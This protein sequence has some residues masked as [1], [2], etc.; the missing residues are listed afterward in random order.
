MI[1]NTEKKTVPAWA[2]ALP[3]TM[4]TE[5]YGGTTED[6]AR[7][8]GLYDLLIAHPDKW[9]ELNERFAEGFEGDTDPAY[10]ATW[11][12]A[13]GEAH[14]T[15]RIE[16]LRADAWNAIHEIRQQ[17]LKAAA[18]IARLEAGDVYD[19]EVAENPD[20]GYVKSFIEDIRKAGIAAY[21]LLPFDE[22]GDSK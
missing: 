15:M 16:S 8:P 4:P 21:A 5:V 10:L 13:E 14:R 18:A 6:G 22:N 12:E 20:M 7:I 9:A 2:E 19:V 11:E 17:G 1:T 3:K